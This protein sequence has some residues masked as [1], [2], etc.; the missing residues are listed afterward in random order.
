[1]VSFTPLPLYLR[2]KVPSGTHWIGSLVGLK[3]GLD[4]VEKRQILSLTGTETRPSNRPLKCTLFSNQL[5]T[6]T[7]QLCVLKFLNF[8][9]PTALMGLRAAR[10]GFESR[11]RQGIFL[12]CTASI[13]ARWDPQDLL[14]SGYPGVK[15]TLTSI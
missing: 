10:S 5:Y 7:S 9:T 3:T 4:A 15:L 1:V 11:R 6:F 2:G 12:F 8:M 13:P 14:C